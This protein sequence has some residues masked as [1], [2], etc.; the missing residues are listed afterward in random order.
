MEKFNILFSSETQHKVLKM[1]KTNTLSIAQK[2][3]KCSTMVAKKV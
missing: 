1:F 2:L 3:M